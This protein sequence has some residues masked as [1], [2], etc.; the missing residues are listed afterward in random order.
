LGI[1]INKELNNLLITDENFEINKNYIPD[2]FLIFRD[3]DQNKPINIILNM[4]KTPIIFILFFNKI[5]QSGAAEINIFFKED[6]K[7]LRQALLGY[8]IKYNS[9]DKFDNQILNIK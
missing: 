5:I 2:L 1:F 9:I 3:L 6:T 4:K 8:N 7:I